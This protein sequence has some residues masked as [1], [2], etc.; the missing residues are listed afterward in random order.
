MNDDEA[1]QFAEATLLD[2]VRGDVGDFKVSIELR[3]GRYFVRLE[4][5]EE[6]DAPTLE[7]ASFAEAWLTLHRAGEDKRA[8]FGVIQGGK[9]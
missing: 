2:V 7:G 9:V 4:V 3:D 1:R 5:P 8:R 6:A